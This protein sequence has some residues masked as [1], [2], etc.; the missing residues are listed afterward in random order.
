[1]RWILATLACTG[2]N[3]IFG[4]A[5]TSLGGDGGGGDDDAGV[6][7]DAAPCASAVG[8]DEDLDGV[9]DACDVCP[10]VYDPDQ[11]DTTEVGLGGLSPDGV[12]DA[13]D[14]HPAG[15]DHL[16][17]FDGFADGDTADWF[18]IGNISPVID[19]DAVT[20]SPTIEGDQVYFAWSFPPGADEEVTVA[21]AID[22]KGWVAPASNGYRAIQLLSRWD[23]GSSAYACDLEDDV[24]DVNPA[25]LVMAR[26]FQ[27]AET[28]L[29]ATI[30][31]NQLAAQ[32][33]VLTLSEHGATFGCAR[34]ADD[35]NASTSGGDPMPLP[36]GYVG[37]RIVGVRAGLRWF[38][39][40][41]G[42]P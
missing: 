22:V 34:V 24:A 5:P 41:A 30:L 35:G 16:L 15:P 39:A 9:D 21:A 28:V 11:A 40:I 26:D 6:T 20:F 18:A 2:C 1:M 14:P 17:V 29:D 12:G 32:A 27:G 36:L 38:V 33:N 31:T 42:P 37:V 23:A 4:L 10:H 13:C 3:A 8:H 7:G 19:T 25:Q